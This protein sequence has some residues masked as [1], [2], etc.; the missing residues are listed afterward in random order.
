[1]Q[2]LQHLSLALTVIGV[3]LLA[4]SLADALPPTWALVGIMALVA[5]IVK[6]LVVHLWRRVLPVDETP[7]GQSTLERPSKS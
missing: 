7:P 4:A 6:V 2:R 5:G 3:V 1:M